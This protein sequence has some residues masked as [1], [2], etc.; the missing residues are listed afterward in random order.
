MNTL[1]EVFKKTKRSECMKTGKSLQELAAE[2]DRQQKVKRDLI[3]D[4]S[5]MGLLTASNGPVLTV[6]GLPD[7][8]FKVNDVAHRQI[9]T[10]LKIPAQY[11]DRMLSQDQEL[12]TLNV[13]RWLRH[14]PSPRMLRTLDGTVRAFLSD[15]YRR[16]DNH[17]IAQTVLPIIGKMDGAII[18]SC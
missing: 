16:I 11:Y 10:H 6:D 3:A 7:D 15:R 5:A 14:E 4:T 1:G 17:E 18:E 12:L 8:V 2:L 13:N 9:G